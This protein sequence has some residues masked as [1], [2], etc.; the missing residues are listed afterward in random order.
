MTKFTFLWFSLTNNFLHKSK[1]DGLKKFVYYM[2]LGQGDSGLAETLT[3][4][5]RLIWQV[6]PSWCSHPRV[7]RFSA[8]GWTKRTL[9][10]QTTTLSI[11]CYYSLS[12]YKFSLRG[13]ALLITFIFDS[14]IKCNFIYIILELFLN[15]SFESCQ[16]HS[17]TRY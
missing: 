6:V 4:C 17:S 3:F 5:H 12:C 10:L 2:A 8:E 7:I 13:C 16:E 9:K 15:T 11:S 14:V 1:V